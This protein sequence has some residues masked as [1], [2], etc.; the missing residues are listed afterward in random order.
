[1][2]IHFRA[3][4]LSIFVLAAALASP[5]QAQQALTPEDVSTIKTDVT[6]MMERYVSALN[7][8]DSK[9]IGESTFSNPSIANGADGVV[10]KTP[11]QI[12]K[13]YAGTN[14]SLIE[15]GWEKSVIGRY[16]ICV[17][18]RNSALA[19]ISWKRVKKD[20]YIL[21]EGAGTYVVIKDKSGWHITMILG[22]A[23]NKMVTCT[24]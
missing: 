10:V 18:S 1:M 8:L 19:D 11:E 15:A 7:R 13:Q 24:N 4:V 12:A 6:A 3:I 2:A 14:K 9:Y 16:D 23:L 20:G 17:L 21:V 22:H 5:V